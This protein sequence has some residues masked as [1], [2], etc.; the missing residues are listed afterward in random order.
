MLIVALVNVL[1]GLGFALV[2]RDRVKADG[3]FATPAF[4]PV[5]RPA[6]ASAPPAALYSYPAHA[7]WAWMYWVDPDK[8]SGLAVIPLMVGHVGLVFGGWY[9]G[10][11]LIRH[12]AQGAIFY[13]GGAIVLVML[14]LLV[15]GIDRLATATDFIGYPRGAG[16]SLFK[17]KL[18]YI[19]V[20]AMLA[21]FGSAIYVSIELG[22][23]GRRVRAR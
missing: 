7:A 21:L 6:G 12:N 8:L 10:A 20:F 5:M 16:I 15:L 13:G 3:P 17:V 18:G 2:A 22:R 19:Y 23:D 14:I 4:Q 11:I 9:A 1:F